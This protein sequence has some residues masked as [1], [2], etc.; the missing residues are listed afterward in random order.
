MVKENK[1]GAIR[2]QI[3]DIRKRREGVINKFFGAYGVQN[4]FLRV[5]VD[6]IYSPYCGLSV[7]CEESTYATLTCR[8][9]PS[10]IHKFP[11]AV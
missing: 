6:N 2:T 4:F 5:F 1:Q 11:V 8:V 3:F 9:T 10:K 7:R